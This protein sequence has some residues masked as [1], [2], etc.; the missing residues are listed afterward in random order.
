MV[1][2]KDDNDDDDDDD[3]DY[4]YYDM[5][6]PVL[7]ISTISWTFAPKTAEERRNSGEQD[8]NL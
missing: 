8:Q 5:M 6:A 4:D 2:L 7:I 1:D 3:D